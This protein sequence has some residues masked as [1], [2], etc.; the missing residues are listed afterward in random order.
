MS[1]SPGSFVLSTLRPRL[2]SVLGPVASVILHAWLLPTAALAQDPT[3]PP[4]VDLLTALQHKY[5]SV[6]DF[7]A[8][9][10]HTYAG[11]V[12]R[13]KLVERGTVLIKK[14]GMM[15][16]DYTEPE[17]KAFVSDGTTLYS[18]IPVDRQVLVGQ[19][20]PEDPAS[21][22]V[23]FLAGKGDLTQDFTAAYSEAPDAP[24]DTWIIRLTPRQATVDYE[25]L[26]LAVDRAG[27]S[28]MQFI[29]VDFQG[30][31]ST[32]T[33][34]N[35]RENENLPDRLFDFHIPSGTEVI[36]EDSFSR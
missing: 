29:A 26:T 7:S 36:T 23:L 35:L 4:I 21:T 27:L 32:F 25:W 20:P 19:V 6:R 15:R 33:F 1:L 34:T 5:D 17:E 12:L 24:P 16:W 14:P 10:E 3:R 8:N 2:S 28:I 11:G 18:H 30:A 22:P 9:F 13:T 31:V